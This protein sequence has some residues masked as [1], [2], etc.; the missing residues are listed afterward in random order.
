MSI[1]HITLMGQVSRGP[2][3]RMTQSGQPTITFT[4]AV[5]RPAWKEGSPA[6][7]DYIRVVA[8]RQLAERLRDSLHKDDLVVVEGRM[9]T[10]SYDTPD[11]Q[12]RKVVEV[13]ATSASAVG[14]AAPSE[15]KR[16]APAEEPDGPVYGDEDDDF[17]SLEAAPPQA[18]PKTF[19]RRAGAPA[20]GPKPQAVASAPPPDFD[21]EIPF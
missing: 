13:E 6:S 3:F 18:A 4:V 7:V 11:G 9:V 17:S 15:A 21:D 8:W 2:E 10:R 14:A 16:A 12:R 5:S 1:N 19:G 20:G